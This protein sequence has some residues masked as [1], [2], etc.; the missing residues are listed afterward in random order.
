MDFWGPRGPWD[1]T[2]SKIFWICDPSPFTLGVRGTIFPRPCL[3]FAANSPL[4]LSLSD[5]FW[6]GYG[7]IW[8]FSTK[9]HTA[10]R[11]QGMLRLSLSWTKTTAIPS[12]TVIFWL[13]T[14]KWKSFIQAPL[15]RSGAVGDKRGSRLEEP[16]LCLPQWAGDQDLDSCCLCRGLLYYPVNGMIISHSEDPYKPISIVERHITVFERWSHLGNLL[17]ITP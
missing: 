16:G 3:L 14:P 7:S 12:F 17:Y 15:K 9:N 11:P 10:S 1:N 13:I 5:L 4:Y 6:L 8:K 2:N